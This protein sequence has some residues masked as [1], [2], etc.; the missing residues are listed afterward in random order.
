MRPIRRLSAV[1]AL[2]V[3]LAGGLTGLVATAGPAAA[4]TAP[5]GTPIAAGFVGDPT[6]GAIFPHGLGSIHTCTASVIGTQTR[7]F[8]LTAAHCLAGRAV[9]WQYAPAYDHG[10]TPYG[11]WTVVHAYLP[12]PWLAR[13]D[14]HYDYA[15]LQLARQVRN[16][17]LVGI[18]EVTGANRIGVAPT[19]GQPVT[20][21]AYNEGRNDVPVTCTV[22]AYL[23]SSYPSFDCHDYVGGSSGSPW[24]TAS[25]GTTIRVTRGVIGGLHQGGCFEFTSYTAPFAADIWAFIKRAE[26]R[27]HPDVAPI[28]GPSGC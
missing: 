6:V 16:G 23:T 20:D 11:V 5:P 8:V 18:Q 19:A 15:L 3:G 22:P 25:P 7:D 27:I 9:G 24:L 28:P 10:H 4:V 14:P 26:F 2:L 13:Q 17:R 1:A 12:T 21:V